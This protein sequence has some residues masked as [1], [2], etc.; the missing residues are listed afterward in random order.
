LAET[1]RLDLE[2]AVTLRQRDHVTRSDIPGQ[3]DIFHATR[4]YRHRQPL[5]SGH[6]TQICEANSVMIDG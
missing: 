2:N 6:K 5:S 4:R 1:N 3:D